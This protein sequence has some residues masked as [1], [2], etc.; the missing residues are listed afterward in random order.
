VAGR[1]W[2][3]FFLPQHAIAQQLR[4]IFGKNVHFLLTFGIF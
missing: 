3:K 4:K 2:E 1:R